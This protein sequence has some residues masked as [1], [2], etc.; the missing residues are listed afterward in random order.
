MDAADSAYEYDCICRGTA[1]RGIL[2]ALCVMVI[3]Y[4]V[5]VLWVFL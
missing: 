4:G 5:V 2:W 3:I 1:A